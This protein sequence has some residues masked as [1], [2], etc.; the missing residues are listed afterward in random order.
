MNGFNDYEGTTSYDTRF[1]TD[2][3]EDEEDDVLEECYRRFD[4]AYK[5]QQEIRLKCLQDRRFVYVDG[6][7]W[8]DALRLQFDNKPRFEVNKLHMACVRIFNEYRN[9]RVSVL[10][11]PTDDTATPD[12]AEFLQG[13]FRADEQRSVAQEAYDNAF[14]E[15]VAGGFGAWRLRNDYRDDIFFNGHGGGYMDNDADED[16]Q[17]IYI[18][19]IY[20][21]DSSVFWNLGAKRADKADATDCWVV[22]SMG[23][24]EYEDRFGVEPSTFRKTQHMTEFDWYTP[25]VVYIA[26]WY[27]VEEQK[28]KVHSY[29][30]PLTQKKIHLA[31]GE[32]EDG[33]HD[34]LLDQG[35]IHARKRTVNRRR[36]YKRIIDGN[37]VLEDIGYIAG[38]NIPIVPFYGKRAYI[39]NQERIMGHVRLGKDAQRLFNMEVSQ[40]AATAALS[41]RQKPIFTPEQIRG[42]EALWA[43]DNINDYPFMLMNSS[44]G[45]NG[46]DMPI[47]P[48]FTQPPQLPPALVALIQL[49]GEAIEEVTGQQQA[50]EE[51]QSNVS[52]KAVELVQT[53]VDMQSFIYMDNFARAMKRTGEIWLG[54]AREVYARKG[55]TMNT[56]SPDGSMARTTIGSVKMAQNGAATTLTPAAGMFDVVCDVGP[57]FMARR[58]ATVRSLTGMLQ[59]IQDPQMM[60]TVTS[61]ILMNME[62]EGLDDLHQFLRKQLLVQGVIKPT[63]EEQQMLQQMQQ[64]AQKPTPE[65]MLMAAEAQEVQARARKTDAEVEAVHAK[66]ARDIAETA[67]TMDN[68]TNERASTALAISEHLFAQAQHVDAQNMQA[69]QMHQS[70]AQFNAQLADGQAARQEAAL[71]QDNQPKPQ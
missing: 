61:L 60:S 66:T 8:E 4:M 67:N 68:I 17:C 11:R 30:H 33:D 48:A 12:L 63:P 42:H 35:Y 32:M 40:L 23:Y 58:D 53:R 28:Y 52:A 64:Q 21:A 38:P 49:S 10:F 70:G 56:M 31:E 27:H 51:L 14:D 43:N 37:K 3:Q 6:A 65:Q 54:M 9:N 45:P 44:T 22:T 13:L 39:D 41:P 47:Q 59:F 15:G 29:H 55:R 34:D 26:E 24:Q 18:E 16:D 7:Q 71:A 36:V 69:A 57:S 2:S 5:S 46:E 20:D 25:D 50:G 62:G 1:P 19:P